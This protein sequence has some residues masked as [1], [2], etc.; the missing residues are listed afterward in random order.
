MSTY[1]EGSGVDCV[2]KIAAHSSYTELCQNGNTGTT[3][4]CS[5]TTE[6]PCNANNALC[7]TPKGS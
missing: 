5:K 2:K 3:T 7:S 1:L 4:L 6:N